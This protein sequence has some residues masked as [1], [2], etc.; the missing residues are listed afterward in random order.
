[1]A[2]VV[3]FPVAGLCKVIVTSRSGASKGSGRS[4]AASTMEKIAV[5]APMPS[6]KVR[7]AAVAK[8]GERRRIR[9]P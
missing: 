5:L 1:M 9:S 3:F 7:M 8:P 2:P 6:A 4:T